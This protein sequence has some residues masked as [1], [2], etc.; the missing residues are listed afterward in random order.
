MYTVAHVQSVRYSPEVGDLVVGRISEVCVLLHAEV[1][2][3][4]DWRLISNGFL[5]TG[6]AQAVESRAE[7][8]SR[9]GAH[10]FFRKPS[11][12]DSGDFLQS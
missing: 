10:A 7:C 1:S 9:W 8:S 4:F 2:L 12:R 5:D 11:W 6:W 3:A